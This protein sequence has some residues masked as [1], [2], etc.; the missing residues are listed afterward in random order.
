MNETNRP[1]HS[2][3]CGCGGSCMMCDDE[4]NRPIDNYDIVRLRRTMLN[5]GFAS[6]VKA[7]DAALASDD[8]VHAWHQC[9]EALR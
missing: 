9:A 2:I 3:P 5:R 6:I 1:T 8:D 7:C 4:G